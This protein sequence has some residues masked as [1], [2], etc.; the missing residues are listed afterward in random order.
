[1]KKII[2]INSFLLVLF[3]GI[4]SFSLKAQNTGPVA[5]EAMQFEPVDAT[6]MV[7][8][9]TGDFTYVLPLLE[10]PGPGGGYP[11]VLNYHSGIGLEQEASWVGIGWN[12]NTGAMN[13]ASIGYPDDWDGASRNTLFF[14]TGET[15]ETHSF[16]FGVM[17]MVGPGYSVALNWDSHN[18]SMY[19]TVSMNAGPVSLSSN[20][21]TVGI[22]VGPASIGLGMTSTGKISASAKLS[23][24]GTDLSYSTDFGGNN[25]IGVSMEVGFINT[26][27]S[28]DLKTKSSSIGVS[29]PFYSYHSTS[30][31]QS[32]YRVNVLKDYTIIVPIPDIGIFTYHYNKTHYST[33]SSK[34]FKLYGPLYYANARHLRNGTN[35]WGAQDF[36]HVMDTYFTDVK[37]KNTENITTSK[38]A[39]LL[40]A[41]DRFNYIAQGL[42]G[43]A[44][45]KLLDFGHLMGEGSIASTYPDDVTMKE[46]IFS[47]L[48][49]E[50]RWFDNNANGKSYLYPDFESSSY[51]EV[52]DGVFEFDDPTPDVVWDIFYNGGDATATMN[53]YGQNRSLFNEAKQRK[54][55]GRY[56]EYFTN[57]EITE[58]YTDSHSILKNKTFIDSK[59]LAGNRS[60]LPQEGIGAIQVIDESGM[61]YHFSLAV[62]QF[63]KHDYYEDRNQTEPPGRIVRAEIHDLEPY[64]YT[65][66]LTA[67]TGPD[68]IDCVDEN[69]MYCSVG[70]EDK[71][72]WIYFHHGKWTD[73]Y[74]WQF[75]YNGYEVSDDGNSQSKSFGRKQIY[76][77]DYIQTASHT[78]YFVK[79]LRYDALGKDLSISE[80]Y[81]L[82]GKTNHLFIP[83]TNTI[84]FEGDEITF[85][86]PSDLGITYGNVH[87]SQK[88]IC[89][90][91][92]KHKSLKLN[93]IILV[94]NDFRI[95]N[96]ASSSND[97]IA[98]ESHNGVE[99]N[100]KLNVYDYTGAHI[101]TAEIVKDNS[102]NIY[103]QDN[104][105]D[106]KDITD[107]PEIKSNAIKIIKFNH[108][109]GLAR[110]SENSSSSIYKAKLTLCDLQF[111][112]QNEV[113]CMPPFSFSYYGQNQS[114]TLYEKD[115]WGF[116]K[117]SNEFMSLKKI[118]LPTGSTIN[119]EYEPDSYSKNLSFPER[120]NFISKLIRPNIPGLISNST[121]TNSFL[122]STNDENVLNQAFQPG[123]KVFIDL[124]L[125]KVINESI[126]NAYYSDYELTVTGRQIED[127]NLT[128]TFEPD[129]NTALDIGFEDGF[130]VTDYLF[131]FEHISYKDYQILEEGGIRTRRVCINDGLEDISETLYD[132]SVQDQ[133][134]SKSWSSGVVI[135]SP[136]DNELHVPYITELP[137]PNVLYSSVKV[138]QKGENNSFISCSQHDFDVPEFLI[139]TT[140]SPARMLVLDGLDKMQLDKFLDVENPQHTYIWYDSENTLDHDSKV[141]A[142]STI[143]KDMTNAIGRPLMVTNYN[144]EGHTISQINYKYYE[145]GEIPLGIVQESFSSKRR[146]IWWEA[147]INNQTLSSHNYSQSNWL[148]NGVS[149]IQYPSLISSI[150]TSSKDAIITQD[151]FIYDIHTGSVISSKTRNNMTPLIKKIKS[152]PAYKQYP[153]MGSPLNSSESN[154]K[155]YK[156]ML[157]QEAA[158]YTSVIDG[159]NEHYVGA[160]IQTWNNEWKYREYLTQYKWFDV[161]ETD[162]WRKHRTYSW[163]GQVDAKGY[164]SGF[165]EPGTTEWN[166]FNNGNEPGNW[167]KTGEITRYTHYSVP[168]E[169]KDINGRYV[170]ASKM[171]YDNTKVVATSTNCAYRE[172]T[173][174]GA[175]DGLI[176]NS[177]Y[178]F[179]SEVNRQDSEIHT[180]TTPHTGLVHTGVHSLKI[181]NDPDKAGPCFYIKEVEYNIP[182][183]PETGSD[184]ELNK[185]YK[186]SVWVHKDSKIK[187]RLSYKY[188]NNNTAVAWNTV[189]I[190]PATAFNT[191]EWYL[192]ELNIP[193]ATALAAPDG[194]NALRVTV[195]ASGEGSNPYAYVDDFRVHP[196][197]ASMTS[198][199]YDNQTGAVTAILDADNIATLY[200][201]DDA[202]RLELVKT[203]TP[204][205]FNKVASYRHHYQGEESTECQNDLRMLNVQCNPTILNAGDEISLSW[206]IDYGGYTL[207]PL[208]DPNHPTIPINAY[209]SRDS[210]DY[211]N[212][213]PLCSM[214]LTETSGCSMTCTIPDNIEQGTWYIIMILNEDSEKCDLDESNNTARRQITINGPDLAVSCNNTSTNVY[215]V[216]DPLPLSATITNIG[217]V[218]SGSYAFKVYFSDN[219]VTVDENN[220]IAE[221]ASQS[222]DAGL[223]TNFNDNTFVIPQNLSVGTHY[224]H[225]I[226][227]TEYDINEMD[228]T[229]NHCIQPISIIPLPDLSAADCSV[230]PITDLLDPYFELGVGV[231][232]VGEYRSSDFFV[233]VYISESQ[234]ELTNAVHIGRDRFPGI[235]PGN[236]S[237]CPLN[238]SAP[239]NLTPKTYYV[240]FMVNNNPDF[241]EISFD[242][243]TCVFAV[244]LKPD[245]VVKSCDAQPY[246]NITN[247]EVRLYANVV[248]QGHAIAVPDADPTQHL[249]GLYFSESSDPSDPYLFV[250]E[251]PIGSLN[252]GQAYGVD[253]YMPAQNLTNLTYYLHSEADCKDEFTNEIN[254]NNNICTDIFDAKPD[255]VIKRHDQIQLMV[256]ECQDYSVKSSVANQG[257]G[258]VTQPFAYK[259]FLSDFPSTLHNEILLG[260]Y[261]INSL[262]VGAEE[263]KMT[264]FTIPQGVNGTKYLQYWADHSTSNASG[265]ISEINESNNRASDQ[266]GIKGIP[267]IEVLA[268]SLNPINGAPGI[269][270]TGT[271]KI[272]NTGAVNTGNFNLAVYITQGQ[273]FTSATPV[274]VVPV[275]SIQSEQI[276]NVQLSLTIPETAQNGTYWITAAAD[277][278]YQIS[279]CEEEMN[280]FKQTQFTVQGAYL[281]VSPTSKLVSSYGG[282]QT[283]TISSNI[284]WTAKANMRWISIPNNT[285]TGD[286]YLKFSVARNYGGART[287]VITITGGGI[288]KTLTITQ[289]ANTTSRVD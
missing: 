141:H 256:Q 88:E 225:Y 213:I 219:S 49:Q 186:A 287:A 23:Y 263:L 153:K 274:A 113:E 87:Y 168:I 241:N 152:I 48:T 53:L 270:V 177:D 35:D 203:E 220:P 165:T 64:A 143:F 224:I 55:S 14:D 226:A 201:Y 86:W 42:S 247:P 138:T 126:I 137:A 66:L 135:Y 43:S 125:T 31:N 260:N 208:N 151:E 157:T 50:G 58:S 17:S 11:V 95:E 92:P 288:T 246:P 52:S 156:N 179:G 123:E 268:L 133:H 218:A 204:D 171:G 223:S 170:G 176:S 74:Y 251:E 13:R 284:S 71:G 90:Q 231:S 139:N 160:S 8:L 147:D 217:T 24:G 193:A 99:I 281:S 205:G 148:L 98:Q 73:G 239:N 18:K 259:V 32:D 79:D 158:S 195:W 209:L 164:Y 46:V 235:M 129:L 275:S 146:Y 81:R 85:E 184:I 155:D 180:V 174:S 15:I 161:E 163:S 69:G 191:G 54:G 94:D 175:E 261:T 7:N 181:P 200:Y 142:R 21:A 159:A 178:Y 258:P 25:S 16:G 211:S 38:L 265:V 216:G 227:D 1:M 189:S 202:G 196:V 3:L 145:K 112:G 214:I 272:R 197:E 144:Q 28:V 4:G 130:Q 228:E 41:Y 254:E 107:N 109:Y 33:L 84:H 194:I 9:L 267:E 210:Y 97:F 234:N 110:D 199:V 252:P 59:S 34:S 93:E 120:T 255:L 76:Y 121:N 237:F 188:F 78:A 47:S 29:T 169:G 77:L 40:P 173:Y 279:E 132:Y 229:N 82:I 271:A 253:E 150:V 20:G 30:P 101:H 44:S 128:I 91:Q 273:D 65:W 230:L 118:N 245:L 250:S 257:M 75:P 249:V 285:G 286:G 136:T 238:L 232:N 187:T 222:L 115:D 207:P 105:I 12:I 57:K 45:F 27:M 167:R 61:T 278:D 149:R 22:G 262:G 233:D 67:I 240:H 119:I 242:N 104:V 106:V 2:L 63:D 124:W 51:F 182:N 37:I 131:N 89:S 282:A 206:S 10:V 26:S 117:N 212:M 100:Y 62:Y 127:G 111:L 166:D 283:A 36:H 277:Y 280:N 289:K 19:G 140:S 172:F 269:T 243:N 122:V 116:A 60:N 198:Y 264:H 236:S 266:Y 215:E 70:I 185:P 108:N 102:F 221:V 56:I 244:E 39:P 276:Q 96:I 68:Y 162:I 114:V 183:E 83:G 103:Y 154:Q 6:D 72:Y 248:N 192:L 5:P 134:P 190:D 80:D